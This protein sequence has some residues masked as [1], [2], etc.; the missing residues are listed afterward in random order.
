MV[1]VADDVVEQSLVRGSAHFFKRTE[2]R[3][4][5]VAA[6]TAT[7]GRFY[8]LSVGHV[9]EPPPSAGCVLQFGYDNRPINGLQCSIV[10]AVCAQ[11]FQSIHCLRARVDD[12]PNVFR[13]AQA[14]SDCDAKDLYFCDSL[15]AWYWR[16]R[17][18]ARL[19]AFVEENDFGVFRRIY[20]QIVGPRP[21]LAVVQLCLSTAGVYG[22]NNNLRI[23]SELNHLVAMRHWVKVCCVYDVRRRT[24]A[25]TL[26]YASRYILER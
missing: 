25:G 4:G 19:S 5:K 24:D 20:L 26:N 23:I 3:R 14:I 2:V 16:R 18:H 17:M 6:R 8:A 7:D 1:F 11:D 9:G 21:C 15:D 12:G 10:H 13:H 22:W